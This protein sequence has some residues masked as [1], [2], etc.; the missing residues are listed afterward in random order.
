M[1]QASVQDKLDT[2]HAW[3]LDSRL[4]LAMDASRCPPGDTPVS[5]VSGGERRRV[6]LCRLLLE[7]ARY[8]AVDELIN[9]LDAETQA[10]LEKHLQQYQGTI[11]AVMMTALRTTLPGGF[12]NS[13]AA[14]ASRGRAIIPP[15]WSRNSSAWHKKPAKSARQKTL[16][17]E[18]EWRHM[19]P[20]ARQAKAKARINQYANLLA[21]AKE[22]A[23]EEREITIPPD[24]RFGDVVIRA[25]GLA[26]SYGTPCYM[27]I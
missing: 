19:S 12:W 24:P 10:W 16:Q 22:R 17:R 26:K 20:R 18:L 14:M 4:E 2:M 11:I 7:E 15:G 5:R 21:Q 27:I 13:I 8:L 25:E 1:R 6:A 23:N 9:H 3:D